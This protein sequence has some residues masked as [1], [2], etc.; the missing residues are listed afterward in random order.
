MHLTDFVSNT[1]PVGATVDIYWGGSSTVTPAFRGQIDV[2]GNLLF[3]NP[4]GP[5]LSYHVSNAIE[6]AGQASEYWTG[7]IIVPP[8]GATSFATTALTG[9]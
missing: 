7:A 8:P 2:N 4:P 6:D 3:P 1:P 9:A 5:L